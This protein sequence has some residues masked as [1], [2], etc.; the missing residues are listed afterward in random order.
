MSTQLRIAARLNQLAPTHVQVINESNQ[1]NV[2]PGAESHFKV[3]VVSERFVGQGLLARHRMINALLS[4]EL[5]TGVHA[6]ALHTLTPDEWRQ[7]DPARLSSPAC[8]GGMASE[9]RRD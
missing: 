6:L 1:H 8:L 3:I 5:A 4:T 7:T 2:A 9:Q